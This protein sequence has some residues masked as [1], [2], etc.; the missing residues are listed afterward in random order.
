VHLGWVTFGITYFGIVVIAFFFFGMG[1]LS[2]SFC[3]FYNGILTSQSSFNAFTQTSQP[4]SFNRIFAK[5]A[6]CF[7]GNGSIISSF[8]LQNEIQTVSLL[9]GEINNYLDM[10]DS[11]KAAYVNLTLTPT[12]INGWINA[13]GMYQKGIYVDFS[14]NVANDTEENPQVALEGMNKYTNNGTAG[15]VPTCTFDY[16][17]FD[18]INCTGWANETNYTATLTSGTEFNSRGFL[19]ISLNDKFSSN[20]TSIW[21]SSDIANR[22]IQQRQCQ[23]NTQAYDA[24]MSYADSITNYRDSRINL[25]QD[26]KDQLTAVLNKNT[27]LNTKLNAFTTSIS[28]FVTATS[29]LSTL[30]TNQVSGVDYASNCTA[31]A[32]SLRLFYNIFCVSFVYKSVQF[33]TNQTS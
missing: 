25:Y 4:T 3:Q 20:S 16:W 11:S 13:M 18:N 26:L 10:L 2:Y 32:N 30:V 17:V 15:I 19:C 22:Y 33:G 1:G 29:A 23:G 31:V 6:T 9:Y 12:K 5:M 8:N 24:I 27:G 14:S 21:T 7:Y 28:A